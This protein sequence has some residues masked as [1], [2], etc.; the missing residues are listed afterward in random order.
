MTQS[1]ESIIVMGKDTL[2]LTYSIPNVPCFP[3]PHLE[4]PELSGID[5]SFVD[6][7]ELSGLENNE[8]DKE[9]L[10]RTPPPKNCVQELCDAPVKAKRRRSKPSIIARRLKF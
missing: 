2:D 6:V 10:M 4:L 9:E 7:L 1:K 3:F 5:W 8:S